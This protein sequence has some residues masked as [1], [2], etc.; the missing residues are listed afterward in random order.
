MAIWSSAEYYVGIIAGS[1]P[2]C[3]ALVLQT[4][5]KFRSKASSSETTIGA[6]SS[7]RSGYSHSLQ[8]LSNII[9]A[10]SY[11]RAPSP[12][13]SRGS[14]S[15]RKDH[16][17]MKPWNM[18][19]NRAPSQDSARESILPLHSVSGTT[20]DTKIWK[21]VHVTVGTPTSGDGP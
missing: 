10:L 17:L 19:A 3:R 1:I 11:R 18:K 2:P 9:T 6:S 20:P 12:E 16:I 4:V 7:H 15:L 14:G 21:T 8:T 13:L 5:H